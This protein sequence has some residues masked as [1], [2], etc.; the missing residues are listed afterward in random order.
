MDI[1]S[2]NILGLMSGTTWTIDIS[3]VQSNGIILNKKELL[4]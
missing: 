3:I 4:L 1:R 2:F